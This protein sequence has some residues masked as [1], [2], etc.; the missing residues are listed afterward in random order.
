MQFVRGLVHV[1]RRLRLC[2]IVKEE[3]ENL[4][5]HLFATSW[6]MIGTITNAKYDARG[7]KNRQLKGS[8][9]VVVKFKP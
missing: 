2:M 5:I 4:Q 8:L 7:E 3:I 1:Y 6:G 9:V